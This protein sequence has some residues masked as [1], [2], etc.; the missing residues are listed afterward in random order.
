MVDSALL[1][2]SWKLK[3]WITEVIETKRKLSFF[4]DAPKGYIHFG[5][6]GRVFAVLTA[7]NRKDVKSEEDQIAAFSTLVAYTGRFKIDGDK[8]ITTVDV[9]ADPGMVG[10]DLVR[11]FK[12]EGASLE[13]I[14]A[15]FVS[16]KPAHDLGGKLLQSY[17]LWHR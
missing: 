3:S 11:F 2:G 12:C 9:S 10:K 1:I 5:A 6:D 17:L 13:I 7:E 15:P 16:D 4:G 14:T 8:L